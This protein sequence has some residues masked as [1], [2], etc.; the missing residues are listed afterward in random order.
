MEQ[1]HTLLR[2]HRI[3]TLN[4]HPSIPP[5]RTPADTV[6]TTC[7]K[8]RICQTTAC[9]R[10]QTKDTTQQEW[11]LSRGRAQDMTHMNNLRRQTA[12]PEGFCMRPREEANPL[13]SLSGDLPPSRSDL[14]IVSTARTVSGVLSIHQVLLTVSFEKANRGVLTPADGWNFSPC[15]SSQRP[16]KFRQL[17]SSEIEQDLPCELTVGSSY[18]AI[19]VSTLWYAWIRQFSKKPLSLILSRSSRR[20][21]AS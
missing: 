2:P 14:M 9:R 21:C 19:F 6:H 17:L 10:R 7:R 3:C 12:P 5:R 16:P 8:G 13:P 15:E 18:D 1:R 4:R 20:L 11:N